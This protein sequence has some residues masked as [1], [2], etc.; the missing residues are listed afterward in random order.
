[1]PHTRGHGAPATRRGHLPCSCWRGGPPTSSSQPSPGRPSSDSSRPCSQL[2]GRPA[3]PTW[4]RQRGP[5]PGDSVHPRPDPSA[6]P[7]GSPLGGKVESGA[8]PPRGRESR[9]HRGCSAGL[10]HHHQPRASASRP[11]DAHLPVWSSPPALRQVLSLPFDGGTKAQGGEVAIT[12]AHA[13][14]RRCVWGGSCEAGAVGG[15]KLGSHRRP[16]EGQLDSAAAEV[17]GGDSP[18]GGGSLP[19]AAPPWRAELVGPPARGGGSSP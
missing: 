11:A 9:R 1:M 6:G 18:G 19:D 8:P 12:T 5:H 13:A 4:R 3:R 17:C 7:E 15:S 2:T 16:V 14:A 10:R